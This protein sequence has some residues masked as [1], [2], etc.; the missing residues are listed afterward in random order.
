MFNNFPVEIFQDQSFRQIWKEYQTELSKAKTKMNNQ[1]AQ[2]LSNYI[3]QLN[4]LKQEYNQKKRKLNNHPIKEKTS[5]TV[6]FSGSIKNQTNNHYQQ[7]QFQTK[8]NFTSKKKQIK[9]K[10]NKFT[11]EIEMENNKS[12]LIPKEKG[13]VKEKDQEKKNEK[14]K[15]KENEKEQEKEKEKEIEKEKQNKTEI[16]LNNDGNKTQESKENSIIPNT[17]LDLTNNKTIFSLQNQEYKQNSFAYL[18]SNNFQ[19]RTA[20]IYKITNN[21]VVLRGPI[22]RQM[23]IPFSEFENK[24]YSLSKKLISNNIKN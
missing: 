19:N 15:E 4:L 13:I 12:N 16:K 10:Q 24:K 18:H 11:M 3:N 23:E 7:D 6:N 1:L 2:E 9:E 21:S 22:F 8:Q 14:E 17:N 20:L 5:K